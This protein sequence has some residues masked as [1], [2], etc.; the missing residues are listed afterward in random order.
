MSLET[1][2]KQICLRPVPPRPKWSLEPPTILSLLKCPSNSRLALEIAM[3]VVVGFIG[4]LRL[5][6]PILKD[7]HDFGRRTITATL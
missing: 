1:V 2:S 6:G 3:R 4:G 5:P 7:L